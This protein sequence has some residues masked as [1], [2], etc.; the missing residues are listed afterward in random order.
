L[1][2]YQLHMDERV[3]LITTIFSD[4]GEVEVVGQLSGDGAQTFIDRIIEVSAHALLLPQQDGQLTSIKL[5]RSGGQALDTL[6]QQIRRRC[7]RTLYRICGHQA[8][9]PTSLAVPLCYDP[10]ATAQCHGGFGDVWKGQHNGQD[11]AAKALRVSLAADFKPT[12]KVSSPRFAMSINETTWPHTEILQG[13]HALEGAL[14]SKRV[15]TFGCDDDRET[16]RDGIGVDG[17]RERQRIYEGQ[18]RRESVRACTFQIGV[19]IFTW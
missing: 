8:L 4:P 9:I 16:V 13:G 3:Y 1:V 2:S 12:R 17:E 19:V 10:A 6:P 11:V 5:L 18:T 15:T 7:L 14:P